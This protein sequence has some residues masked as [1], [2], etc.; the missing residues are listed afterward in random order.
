MGKFCHVTS[1]R[2]K[3]KKNIWAADWSKMGEDNPGLA[4]NLNSDMKA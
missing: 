2:Q 4:R 1:V 3:K